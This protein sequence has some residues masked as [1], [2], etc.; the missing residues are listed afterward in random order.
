MRTNW[1]RWERVDQTR[2]KWPK[3]KYGWVQVDRKIEKWVRVD[4]NESKLTKVRI[5]FVPSS[6]T[7]VSISSRLHRNV[8]YVTLYQNNHHSSAPITRWPA[9][10]RLW[11]SVFN[12]SWAEKP[13][14]ETS[15]EVARWLVRITTPLKESF[16]ISPEHNVFMVS[17]CDRSSYVFLVRPSIRPT[18]HNFVIVWILIK[19]GW[20]DPRVVFFEICFKSG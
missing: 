8:A 14:D 5:D 3:N 15:L 4:Q 18:N 7:P 6:Y 19:L 13:T 12:F 17:Y 11:K 1:L 20:N 10:L 9:W 16:V 2:T